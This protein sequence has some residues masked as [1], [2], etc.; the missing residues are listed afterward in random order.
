MGVKG[1]YQL[2]GHGM[3]TCAL[4]DFRGQSVACDLSFVMHQALSVG[5]I[6]VDVMLGNNDPVVA[7]VLSRARSLSSLSITPVFVAEQP[8]QTL[9]GKGST[10]EARALRRAQFE[11]LFVKA[12]EGGRVDVGAAKQATSRTEEMTTSILDALRN[13]GYTL[14]VAATENDHQIAHLCREHAVTAVYANDGDFFV[15][16]VPIL[17][18]EVN[19]STLT[20]S[21]F[22]FRTLLG[23]RFCDE[24]SVDISRHLQVPPCA[25]DDVIVREMEQRARMSAAGGEVTGIVDLCRVY[26]R[27]VAVLFAASVGC[28]YSTIVGVGPSRATVALLEIHRKGKLWCACAYLRAQVV[29]F[30]WQII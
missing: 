23:A 10:N 3:R 30:H 17:L 27:I 8:G 15:H 4:S 5:D 24:S 2:L 22:D 14:L 6:A 26:G 9:G 11:S 13:E 28:D 7:F 21:V 25:P 12:L 16:G 1:L 20:V 29:C 18:K 19:W